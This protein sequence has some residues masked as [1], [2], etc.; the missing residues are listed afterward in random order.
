[1]FKIK[2]E[3]LFFSAYLLVAF[4]PRLGSIDV[5]NVQFLFLSIVG[6]TH[7]F[8]NVFKDFH[9]TEYHIVVF[10]F[11]LIFCFSLLSYIPAFNLPE[12]VID[13]S[14]LFTLF[15]IL[16]NVYQSIKQNPKL[17]DF[18][19]KLICFSL[20]IE[21]AAILA[22]FITNYNLTIAEK[23]GRNP[24]YRGL[25]G[26][27]NIAGFA[28]S[29]KSTILIYFI[30]KS[31][32]NFN[33]AGLVILLLLTFFCISLTGSR[34]ALLSIYVI[35]LIFTILNIKIFLNTN[36]R[37]Y[38]FKTL[39]YIIPFSFIFL[40]TELVFD[41]L[42]MSYRTSQIIARGSE[43][44]L[45]YWQSTIQAILDYP[46]L[47]LG[48]G[49]WKILSISYGTEYI[50]DY[51]VPHFSHNDFLQF[52]AEVG[53]LGG[54]LFLAIPLYVIFIILKNYVIQNKSIFDYRFVF[55]LLAIV[56][57][58]IDSS[59]NFPISRPLQVVPY[60][61]LLAIAVGYY[62]KDSIG[63]VNKVFQS[64]AFIF[65]IGILGLSSI[66]VS[67]LNYDSSKD[68][69]HLFLDYNNH[70]FDKPIEIVETWNDKFPSITQTGMP[71]KALKAHY[72]Y[73]SGDTLT[74]IK[75][76]K[77]PPKNDNPFLG[78]YEGKLGQ[79]YYDLEMIDSSYKY[80]RL[81]YNKLSKN[82]LHAG[83]LMNSLV[84]LQYEDEMNE[85][86]YRNKNYEEEGLWHN[87]IRGIYNPAFNTN[88][89]TLLFYLKKARKLF[90]ENDFI[91][92]AKQEQ[93][94][95]IANID[96]AEFNAGLGSK[97]FDS[98]DNKNAYTYY[99]IAHQLLP[100][101]YA[102]LQNM[103]L[104]KINMGEYDEALKMLNY[105]IDSLIIPRDN[106][107]IYA[108]RGGVLLLQKDTYN[109]CRD[110]IVGTKKKDKLS[111]NF[112]LNNCQLYLSEIQLIE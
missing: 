47:G 17:L 96:Q 100:T 88:K 93:E 31:K 106:G 85:V 3:Q 5:I 86:F 74:A 109:A 50:K 58:C 99:D 108:I 4:Y 60:V 18:A 26:N 19:F 52:T 103:S 77:N 67:L 35:I 59:L 98:G 16:I 20:F 111:E 69:I 44:R 112:L 8:Y 63:Y 41:T 79:I 6:L 81:A 55:I 43:S 94:F 9:K 89:D 42:R 7:F 107:R 28:L 34:G 2:K 76:L 65:L 53:V 92:I 73:Q 14:K 37:E 97:Y 51:V 95:G 83:Y 66:Y 21:V 39:F 32:S 78:V 82:L 38:L 30:Q 80:S 61:V 10:L 33:K 84:E 110:F 57:Y 75:I 49:N 29:L 56:V 68:Q 48:M 11:F 70:N 12:A 24:V 102:Y 87:Y 40:L 101:E 105:A 27:I 104:S 45:D 25:S 36:N 46:I 54:L 72:Y 62:N 90:P 91:K 13:S 71:I 1:M 64:K 22:T 23:I 15:L